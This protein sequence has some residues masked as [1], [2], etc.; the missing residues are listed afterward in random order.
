MLG[1]GQAERRKADSQSLD[2]E[3]CCRLREIVR[4]VALVESR[5]AG[6]NG[7]WGGEIE[8]YMTWLRGQKIRGDIKNSTIEYKNELIGQI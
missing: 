4:L 7:I 5:Q 6:S 3:L 1:M 8:S 2:A